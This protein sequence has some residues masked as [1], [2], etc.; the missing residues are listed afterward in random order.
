[1][2]IIFTRSNAVDPDPRLEK[3]VK[4]LISNG[5]EIEVLGWNR[6]GKDNNKS[7]LDIDEYS[8]PIKRYSGKASFGAGIKSLKELL[9]FQFFLLKELLRSRKSV[10]L[11]H[12]ADFDTVIPAF[13]M[14]LFFRKKVIYDIYD[15]YVDSFSVPEKIKPLIRRIDL[16]IV[17]FVDAVIITTEARL[18]QIKGAVPRRIESIHNTPAGITLKHTKLPIYSKKTLKY[19]VT[20][21]YVGILQDGRLLLEILDVFK[22]NP[23]WQLIVAGFGKYEKYF[24]D[25]DREFSNIQFLGKVAYDQ[26]LSI[27]YSADLLFATY[28]PTIQNHRYSSPNKFYEAMMLGKPIIVC[29][30]TGIDALI[31]EQEVGWVIEYS[32]DAFESAV[33]EFLMNKDH[34]LRIQTKM[35]SLYRNKYNWEI[36]SVR[37][38]NLY[39][40]V[41]N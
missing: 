20:V 32:A 19:D 13:L 17:S 11:I 2:K 6:S 38:L 37:L 4:T 22:K 1:M 25:A 12:A 16:F 8:I 34:A 7:T 23:N 15:F 33:K 31:V 26:S 41:L 5:Y 9:L 29:T 35:M 14:K 24:E 39:H 3:E 40:E 36:M 30:G 10:E 18:E 28:D 27:S 21:A